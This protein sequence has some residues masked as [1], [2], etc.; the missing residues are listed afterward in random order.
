MP[1]PKLKIIALPLSE[2]SPD[3]KNA[4]L[5]SERN[6]RDI[7]ASLHR[8][9]QQEPLIVRPATEEDAARGVLTPYVCSSGSGRLIALGRL[10]EGFYDAAQFMNGTSDAGRFP[11]VDVIITTL[12]GKE[13]LAYAISANQT[14]LTSAWDFPELS[15]QVKWLKEQ[16]GDDFDSFSLGFEDFDLQ[17]LLNAAW[18]PAPIDASIPDPQPR[19]ERERPVSDPHPDLDEGD[20]ADNCAPIIVTPNMRETIDLAVERVRLISGDLS[21]SEGR[22]VELACAD[23]LAGAPT[24]EQALGEFERLRGQMPVMEENGD[25]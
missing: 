5:H 9:D 10:H 23:Y 18:D 20:R 2:V 6:L 21:I 15:A 11:A 3:P 4:R 17:P 7:A 13:L 19:K 12:A 25:A 14:G 24:R 1:K 16:E 22:C 8:Y